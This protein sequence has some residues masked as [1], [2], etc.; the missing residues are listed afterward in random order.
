M[1]WVA[2][3]PTSSR[4]CYAGVAESSIYVAESARGRRIGGALM[5]AVLSSARTGGIW[6]VHAGM[7]PENG[8]SVALHGSPGSASSAAS[9]ASRSSTAS[10]AT[11]SCSNS[12]CRALS[13]FGF[14][15]A[16][17]HDTRVVPAESEGVVD[18]YVDL[19]RTRLVGDV[20]QIAVGSGSSTLIV[21]GST[22]RWRARMAR[23]PRWRRR[24]PAGGRRA[25]R[26]ETGARRFFAESELE[27]ASLRES[28]SGSTCRGR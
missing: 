11:P 3:A 21:G 18:T 7:F 26:Q 9:S 16:P 24:R 22:P 19:L 17:E 12:A 27:Y 4:A 8:A 6:T 20:V 15:P 2:L 5:E 10:G 28:P 14:V 25:L 23:W 13:G 1:G